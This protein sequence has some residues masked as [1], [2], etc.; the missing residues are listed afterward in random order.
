VKEKSNNCSR[1][2]KILGGSLAIVMSVFLLLSIGVPKI[3]NTDRESERLAPEE[4]IQRSDQVIEQMERSRQ[5][6][7]NNSLETDDFDALLSV[8]KKS[9][10]YL[11]Q[12]VAESN[13]EESKYSYQVLL[14]AQK[15]SN[16]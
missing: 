2:E 11:K 1:F 14:M 5:E 13:L 16:L 6:L 4:M 3:Q 7:L 15:R 10:D 12:M 8:A 9:N